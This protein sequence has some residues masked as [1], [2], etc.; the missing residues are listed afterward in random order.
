MSAFLPP[1]TLPIAQN[2]ASP[3]SQRKG[4]SS[5][6]LGIDNNNNNNNTQD[7]TS[8][9]ICCTPLPGADPKSFHNAMQL[10]QKDCFGTYF[11]QLD[12]P[13]HPFNII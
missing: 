7:Y 12:G 10:A 2:Q 4:K 3:S 1:P 5:M 11:L 8:Y 6:M 13:F 9:S